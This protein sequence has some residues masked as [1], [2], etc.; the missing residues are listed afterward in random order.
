M[1]IRSGEGAGSPSSA[2]AQMYLTSE[3]APS[4][5]RHLTPVEAGA[6]AA[7]SP[8]AT[9]SSTT[10]AG[11]SVRARARPAIPPRGG[12]RPGSSGRRPRPGEGDPAL[13]GQ[14]RVGVE[15]ADRLGRPGE[16]RGTAD[17]AT[18]A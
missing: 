5:V 13:A 4:T 6:A 9:T 11:G 17:A 8:E 3:A 14:P 15:H 18:L 10:S 2:L 1:S 7:R 12:S 16:D